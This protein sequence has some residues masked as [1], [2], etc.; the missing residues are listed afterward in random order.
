MPY[1]QFDRSRLNVRPLG[2]RVHDITVDAVLPLVAPGDP[3]EHPD[4]PTIAQRMRAA[5][6]AGGTGEEAIYGGRATVD[7]A[8]YFWTTDRAHANMLLTPEYTVVGVGV[9]NVADRYYYTI[10]FGKP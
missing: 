10:D 8:W 6:Y 4:L 7:E 9:V 5:G 2:E 3:L 1:P